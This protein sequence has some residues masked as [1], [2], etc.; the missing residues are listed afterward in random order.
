MILSRD[1]RIASLLLLL[2]ATPLLGQNDYSEDA[3]CV[4]LWSHEGGAL[5]TDSIGSNTL[6][7]VF[8]APTSDQVNYQE[9][10]GSCDYEADGLWCFC[11]IINAKLDAGFPGKDGTSNTTFSICV[12]IKPESL[13]A[14]GSHYIAS[15]VGTNEN[16]YSIR[17]TYNAGT[18]YPEL[19]VSQSGIDWVWYTYGT[20]IVAGNWYHIG[21]TYEGGTYAYRLRIYDL[22]NT[23]IL[24][25]EITGTGP[26]DFNCDTGSFATAAINTTIPEYDGLMDEL[27]VFNDVLSADE[28]DAIRSGTYPPLS[29]GIPQRIGRGIFSGIRG[30][31]P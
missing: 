25:T 28:I 15:K 31:L 10:A 6:V 2:L 26:G 4:A 3:N 20:G 30:I 5:L 12:W 23:Q 11:T 22:T 19:G 17:L 29:A 16:S 8:T 18:V 1:F 14:S 21:A 24:G 7:E 13:P 27:V 9:G